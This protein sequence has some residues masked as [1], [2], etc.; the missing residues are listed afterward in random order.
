MD[1]MVIDQDSLHLEVCL[2]ARGL[3]GVLDE[4]VLQAVTSALV[5]DYFAGE[6][7]AEAAEY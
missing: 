4:G 2:L 5:S 3:L 7:F 1:S 6:N